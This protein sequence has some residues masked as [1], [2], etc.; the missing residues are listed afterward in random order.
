MSESW[1]PA[2]PR[3][4]LQ[5][6]ARM[7]ADIRAFFD[8]RGVL[9]VETPLLSSASSTDPSLGS[10]HTRFRQQH[11]YLN[12]SPEF[13]MKRLLAAYGDA[14]YQVCKSFRDDELGPLHNPEFTMLE[15]YRPGF[16]MFELMDELTDLVRL[17]VN[18]SSITINGINTISYA[19]AFRQAAGIDPHAATAEDCL[20]CARQHGI[21]QPVGLDDDVDA[22]L[23]WLL[24]QL[25][26]PSFAADG[27]TYL[28]GYPQSQAA[29]AKLY[30]DPQGVTVAARFELFYGDIELA[31]GFDE[32]QDANQQRRR[33]DRENRLRVASGLQPAI[34]D[35]YLLDALGHGLPACS[36][37]AVGLDRLLMLLLGHS[38][39]EQV[40]S[41]PFTRI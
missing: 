33:F 4:V 30:Q 13:C 7:L 32:L 25:V 12:T 5:A 8:R 34:I 37:V 21:E 2:A 1:R 19:E 10:F 38:A 22:W 9:E 3:E 26:T 17:L 23:D 41:F 35:E 6:R 28:F 16:D 15:W 40:L 29:L 18:N 14:V 11:L 36:G 27:L 24:I 20:R 31:N 39:V